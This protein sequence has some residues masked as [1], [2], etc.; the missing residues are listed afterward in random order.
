MAPAHVLLAELW[1]VV[2][3]LAVAW[4]ED[5]VW[6]VQHQ[7]AA[8]QWRTG[9]VK[10][11]FDQMIGDQRTNDPSTY[12]QQ[13]LQTELSMAWPRPQMQLSTQQKSE[14]IDE[15][16]DLVPENREEVTVSTQESVKWR[17]GKDRLCA[18][19]LCTWSSAHVAIRAAQVMKVVSWGSTAWIVFGIL[20]MGSQGKKNAMITGIMMQPAASAVEYRTCGGYGSP[21]EGYSGKKQQSTPPVSLQV[22]P[23]QHAV[24]DGSLIILHIIM[25]S[26]TLGEHPP[27]RY[28]ISHGGTML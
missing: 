16:I 4:R 1:Q 13:T 9:L 28:S 10:G 11:T 7:A 24:E 22:Y 14:R 15:R 2:A 6:E 12:E 25:S 5:D 21:V 27:P 23:A 17:A 3:A 26:A 18:I 19:R 8:G 20:V